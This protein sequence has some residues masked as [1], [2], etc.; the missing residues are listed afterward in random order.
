MLNRGWNCWTSWGVITWAGSSGLGAES[1]WHWGL[2][3]TVSV[4]WPNSDVFD[5]AWH[6][7]D[8]L[9]DSENRE[10]KTHAFRYFEIEYRPHLYVEMNQIYIGCVPM[11]PPC[12]KVDLI[13]R[14]HQICNQLSSEYE[15]HW[16]Y[17]TEDERWGGKCATVVSFT[18]HMTT[19]ATF[20]HTCNRTAKKRQK[21]WSGH[22]I[23]Q[24]KCCQSAE[25]IDT[26]LFRSKK[27]EFSVVILFSSV[28]LS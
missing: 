17:V 1:S 15:K 21:I 25:K 8:L 3:Y 12:D 26:L 11:C 5:L 10:K 28:I 7:S 23:L 22:Q 4:M 9:V 27:G 19:Q 24:C 16:G 6:R 2:I 18:G 20:T 14:R 13:L